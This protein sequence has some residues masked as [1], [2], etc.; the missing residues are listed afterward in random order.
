ELANHED[1]WVRLGVA[2]NPNAPLSV[3]ARLAGE[4]ADFAKF[5]HR[6]LMAVAR[7][8]NTAP[9]RLAE[10]ADHEDYRIRDEV[11]ENPGT[12]L[13]LLERLAE[14]I[15]F[16][17][18]SVASN[19]NTPPELLARLV[20]RE[21]EIGDEFVDIRC[22]VASN[23]NTPPELMARLVKTGGDRGYGIL[24]GVA[25]NPH[26]PLEILINLAS[27]E[28]HDIEKYVGGRDLRGLVLKNPSLPADVVARFTEGLQREDTAK[29]PDTPPEILAGLV[30]DEFYWVR[31]AVAAHPRTPPEVLVMLARDADEDVREKV[32]EHPH[33]PLEAL[34]I[35]AEDEDT[36]TRGAVASNLNMP[37]VD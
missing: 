21:E 22:A 17:A 8:P 16:T 24:V 3:L 30:N 37:P 31:L 14:D 27:A 12:P 2:G 10:L 11:A 32:A 18:D 36:G 4:D 23:P 19:P 7:N 9:E 35:L 26:T 13:Y 5:V 28:D 15:E 33:V 34:R 20:D 25:A 1:F 29:N 6:N